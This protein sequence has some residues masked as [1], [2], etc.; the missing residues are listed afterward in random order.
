MQGAADSTADG[1]LTITALD[2]RA[3]HT[4]QEKNDGNIVTCLVCKAIMSELPHL[5]KKNS[6]RVSSLL[7]I[8]IL[9][10]FCLS[11]IITIDNHYDHYEHCC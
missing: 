9:F 11:T 1:T 10:L 8:V 2:L 7:N 6:T 3:S 5:I 4:V